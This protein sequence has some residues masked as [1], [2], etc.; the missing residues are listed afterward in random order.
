MCWEIDSGRNVIPV[1]E[2]FRRQFDVRKV[3]RMLIVLLHRLFG[4]K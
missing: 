2:H 4:S 1:T 3:N